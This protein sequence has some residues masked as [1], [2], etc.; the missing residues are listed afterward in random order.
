MVAGR[1]LKYNDKVLK[2]TKNY[3]DNYGKF[4]DAVPS[5]AGLACVLHIAKS[6]IYDWATH[7]EKKEFSDTLR[8]IEAR[9]EQKLV[10]MGLMGTFNPTIT[11]L[12]LSNHGY[13]E[14]Q[15]IEQTNK[16]IPATEEDLKKELMAIASERGI[17]LE[18][19]MEIEGIG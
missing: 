18:E 9:Q 19:L 12:M 7:K 4:G 16:E 2:D 6:T 14:K 17:T 5:I 13:H 8:E 11:K 1:P 10:S 15:E 3:L